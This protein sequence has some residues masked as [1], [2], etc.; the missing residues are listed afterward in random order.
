MS[1]ISNKLDS[2]EKLEKE[3]EILA[4]NL[5]G[6]P[7]SVF[8][9]I[10]NDIKE[11]KDNAIALEFTKC[12]GELLRKNGVTPMID[13]YRHETVKENS[14]ECRY[15]VA[16]TGLD[17]TEHDK[18]LKDEITQLK[19]NLEKTYNQLME[20][21][22]DAQEKI[23]E[24]ESELEVKENLLKIKN[25][26]CKNELPT[27]ITIDGYKCEIIQTEQGLYIS[28]DRIYEI[29]DKEKKVLKDKCTELED[30]HNKDCDKIDQLKHELSK[31]V[32]FETDRL[33][34]L[35]FDA[36]E[37]ANMLIN[38]TY[39]SKNPF[40]GNECDR[41][42]YDIDDLEQIAEHLLVYCRH[43]REDEE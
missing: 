10:A 37:T 34:K 26:L 29:I 42:I 25:G 36:P 41:N 32:D 8:D 12:I 18:R 5:Q 21:E 14:I 24:L 35:P 38:A 22:K 9:R 16:I 4:K 30:R 43:N 11:Q 13:E 20:V 27:E 3:A 2:I 39:K 1:D 23:A 33:V 19:H 31:K 17:F 6:N 7:F 40:T 15:G 28:R